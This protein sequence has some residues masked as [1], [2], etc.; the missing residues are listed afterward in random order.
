MKCDYR[1]EY[2]KLSLKMY[3]KNNKVIVL[4]FII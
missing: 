2:V 4:T 1:I 3:F